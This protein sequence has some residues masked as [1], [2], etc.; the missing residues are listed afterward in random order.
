M[1]R[2][3]VDAE[4]AALFGDAGDLEDTALIVVDTQRDFVEPAPS[5][6][7]SAITSIPG[8]TQFEQRL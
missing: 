3:K 1:P 2:V 6:S 5:A 8:A 4:S 7:G